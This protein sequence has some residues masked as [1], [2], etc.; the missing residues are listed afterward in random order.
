M[1][2]DRRNLKVGQ[3]SSLAAMGMF[4]VLACNGLLDNDPRD[5]G[6]NPPNGGEGG[7]GAASTEGGNAGSGAT[8]TEGGAAGSGAASTEGGS[9]GS[10]A[11]STEGGAAGSGA[12]SGAASTEGGAAGSGAASTEGG[13]A[14]S[15]ATSS[16]GAAARPCD[17]PARACSAGM[18]ETKTEACGNCGTRTLSR[19]CSASCEWGE[20][21]IGE[22]GGQGCQPGTKQP[23]SVNCSCGGTKTQSRTCSAACAWG[24]WT[25]T[26]SC[27]VECCSEVV[28]CNS[29]ENAAASQSYPGRGTWCREKTPACSPEQALSDCMADVGEYCPAGI[30]QQFH[31]EYH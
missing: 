31:M 2:A 3:R 17:L 9:A 22:C 14:G 10:G 27:D 16:G 28:F 4:V 7:S 13:A 11:T 20:W 26:S 15:G 29:K 8:S 12:A 24:P 23:G 18:P 30:V 6:S 5:L 25:D 1:P 19:T 21:S